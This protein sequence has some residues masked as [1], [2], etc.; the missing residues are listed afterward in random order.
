MVVMVVRGQLDLR[1]LRDH[2][3]LQAQPGL[4]DLVALLVLP[5]GLV[6]QQQVL[7]LLV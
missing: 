7:G 2:R 4:A 5:Q 3:V 1:D 6:L